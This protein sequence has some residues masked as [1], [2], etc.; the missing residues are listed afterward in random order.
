[1]RP[2]LRNKRTS[3]MGSRRWLRTIRTTKRPM[4]KKLS[5]VM[6]LKRVARIRRTNKK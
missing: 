1:M 3:R 4:L 5:K 6:M 2:M